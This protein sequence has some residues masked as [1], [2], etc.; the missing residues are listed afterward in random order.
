M[1]NTLADADTYVTKNEA[2]PGLTP[3]NLAELI[4]PQA[5]QIRKTLIPATVARY[6]DA[7]RAADSA[8]AADGFPPIKVRMVSTA[9]GKDFVPELIV[10][11]HRAAAARRAGRITLTAEVIEATDE[12]ARWISAESNMTHGEPLKAT[13]HREVFKAYVKAG[14]CWHCS[15]LG[16]RRPKSSREIA[17]DLHGL[18]SH[19]TIVNWMRKDF[20]KIWKQMGGE[21]TPAPTKGDFADP[22]ERRLDEALQHLSQVE[23]IAKTLIDPWHRGQVLTALG[24]AG[25]AL[26]DAGPCQRV[27][28]E[29]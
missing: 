28:D 15:K 11:F 24:R 9:D 13:E 26:E 20:P 23:S 1:T 7:M 21:A 22:G 18:R 5:N 16:K 19:T 17:A 27:Q 3:V 12:E 14:R 29:F 25:K 4:Q 10:G 6:A 8:G 2:R